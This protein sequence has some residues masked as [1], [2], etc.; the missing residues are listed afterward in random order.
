[1]G[2]AF[3]DG[4]GAYQGKASLVLELG[5]SE[6]TAVAHGGLELEQGNGNVVF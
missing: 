4:G 3:D 6:C 1:M 5:N 2:T